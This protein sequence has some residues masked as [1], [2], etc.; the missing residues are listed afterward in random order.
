MCARNPV[1]SS[2]AIM[3]D[4]LDEYIDDLL[5]FWEFL[6]NQRL[7]IVTIDRGKLKTL[8]RI[9]AALEDHDDPPTPNR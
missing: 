1:T 3:N 5:A 6:A 8:A 4:E 7:P 2:D 9:L